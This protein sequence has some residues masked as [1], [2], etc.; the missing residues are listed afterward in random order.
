MVK[1]FSKILT[2][3]ALPSVASDVV[4]GGC[5]FW[6]KMLSWGTKQYSCLHTYSPSTAFRN[7]LYKKQIFFFL[8]LTDILTMLQKPLTKWHG[9]QP[10]PISISVLE[11][12]AWLGMM[13][14]HGY[15]PSCA[16][17]LLLVFLNEKF[18]ALALLLLPDLGG[19]PQF[20]PV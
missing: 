1:V 16:S 7:S 19:N 3:S 12:P 15:R 13:C 14:C 5:K 6:L 17:V 4:A 8:V 9:R 2:I 10:L 18:H 11:Q 20:F